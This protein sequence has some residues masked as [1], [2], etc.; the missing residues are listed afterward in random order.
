MHLIG[1]DQWNFSFMP[2]GKRFRTFRRGFLEKYSTSAAVRSF[3]DAQRA[4]GIKFLGSVLRD[5][6]GVFHHLGLRA[7]RLILDVTYGIE[8]ESNQNPFVKTADAMMATASFALSPAMW[9]FNPTTILKYLPNWLG[10]ST[11][12]RWQADC[13][14]L[15][16]NPYA[17]V[18]KELA[19]GS[20]RPSY[21]ASLIQEL[22]PQPGS[23]EETFIRDTAAVAY[24]AASDTTVVASETFLLAMVLNPDVQ[25]RAQAEIDRVVGS[26]R[27][28]DYTDRAQL[29]YVSAVMKEVLR[30]HSPGPTGVPHKLTQDDVYRGYHMPAGALVMGNVWGLLHDPEM[31]P[32]PMEFRPERFLRDGVFDCSTNDPSRYAFGFGR[33][34]CPGKLF[35]ENS[36]WMLIA[37]FLATFTVSLPEGADPPPMEWTSE[38]FSR[39]L[40]FK[41][42]IRPRSQAAVDLIEGAVA[43]RD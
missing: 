20:A 28:P 31:Y 6:D 27:L 2:Y 17:H 9:L 23:D 1:H 34:A 7:S 36:M 24:A 4:V 42:V 12:L 16:Y 39:P 19:H 22:S 11:I 21:V 26:E 35:A 30:W 43:S 18:Q 14:D 32:E 8:A 37:Q 38:A 10:G 25:K 41:C 5:P 15:R 29:P 3:Y 33:R 13:N 40:P